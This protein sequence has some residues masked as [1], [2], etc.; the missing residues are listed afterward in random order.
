MEKFETLTDDALP[1]AII[2]S[3]YKFESKLDYVLVPVLARYSWQK[4]KRSRMK[5]HVALGP[6]AGYLLKAND[7]RSYFATYED[8]A[9]TTLID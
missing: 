6:F 4:S 9:R 5:V 1:P 8:E 3:D 7:V 2:Y